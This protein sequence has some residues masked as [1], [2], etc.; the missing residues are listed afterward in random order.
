MDFCN[1][2]FCPYF[3]TEI[4]KLFSF[5]FLQNSILR[6]ACKPHR[7]EIYHLKIS[8]QRYQNKPFAI[9]KRS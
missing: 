2:A 4:R 8:D 5:P 6:I 7:I 9:S 3:E 1:T